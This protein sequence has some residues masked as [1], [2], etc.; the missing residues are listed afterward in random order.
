MWGYGDDNDMVLHFFL[1]F[2]LLLGGGIPDIQSLNDGTLKGPYTSLQCRSLRIGS[3]KVTPKERVLIVPQGLRIE[4][5][6]IG[7]GKNKT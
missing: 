3:Y 7:D 2:F 6:P 1:F 5:P 4:V